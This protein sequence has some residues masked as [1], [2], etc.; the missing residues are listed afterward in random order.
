MDDTTP[1]LTLPLRGR[2]FYFSLSLR[3]WVFY[4]SLPLRGRVGE[5]VL[6]THQLSRPIEF[7][8]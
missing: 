1:T 8:G 4:F 2:V 5:G 6:L 3:G 7:P